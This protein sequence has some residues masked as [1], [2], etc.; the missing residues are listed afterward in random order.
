M[1]IFSF[2]GD[3][4]SPNQYSTEAVT[5]LQIKLNDI[6]EILIYEETT[7]ELRGVINFN[8]GKSGLRNTIGHY[9]AYT[10]R[11]TGN[12]ELYD[13]VKKTPIAVKGNTVVS[14]EFL[15]YTV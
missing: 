2:L 5:M 13:D 9:S 4:L 3:N 11:G 12:W 15:I 1:Y 6:P 14:C 10:K 8:R 7:Y